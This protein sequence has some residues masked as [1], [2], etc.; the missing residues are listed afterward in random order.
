[1]D[2]R[3]T[4]LL[5]FFMLAIAT[6]FPIET[7]GGRAKRDLVEYAKQAWTAV[8]NTMNEVGENIVQIFKP[9]EPGTLKPVVSELPKYG[10]V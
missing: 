3:L 5:C 10:D 2:L 7:G 4:I 1:M 9:T 6:A 8:M